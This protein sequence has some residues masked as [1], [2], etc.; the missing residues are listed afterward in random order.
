MTRAKPEFGAIIDRH[1]GRLSE[2]EKE[3]RLDEL[4][5]T[6]NAGKF[7]KNCPILIMHGDRDKTVPIEQ[8]ERLVEKLIEYDIPHKYIRIEGGTHV[9]LKDGSYEKIDDYR[10]EWLGKYLV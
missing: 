1:F 5:A 2:A 9:A 6:R 8:S 4:S 3:T 10:R 7:S